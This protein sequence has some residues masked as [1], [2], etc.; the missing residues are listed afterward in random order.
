MWPCCGSNRR[1]AV[2]KIIPFSFH[3]LDSV[4]GGSVCSHLIHI[5]SPLLP[6]CGFRL[7]IGLRPHKKKAELYFLFLL[8]K[9]LTKKRFS[10]GRVSRGGKDFVSQLEFV[11][12]RSV[13]PALEPLPAS[14]RSS[15]T[16]ENVRQA[17]DLSEIRGLKRE[18][19]PA[20][21]ESQTALGPLALLLL[22]PAIFLAAC[23]TA[24]RPPPT[25][26][27]VVLLWL[28]HPHRATDRDKIVRMAHS[29]RRIPGVLQVEAGRSIGLVGPN[30][31]R[32]CRGEE[33][34]A[35]FR[36][37]HAQDVLVSRFELQCL[38]PPVSDTRLGAPP[39][40]PGRQPPAFA[41]RPDALDVCVAP[42]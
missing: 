14:F 30:P 10:Q 31:P 41:R 11:R 36:A 35:A 26:T 19:R 20:R 16:L 4:S 34:A 28:K 1:S 42:S 27:H 6:A 18:M 29:L 13:P 7:E 33:G 38:T 9:L 32:A 21:R 37:Q 24:P 25:V 22:W 3:T 5:R 2:Q 12:R 23:S 39:L 40:A 17:A 15:M 8:K